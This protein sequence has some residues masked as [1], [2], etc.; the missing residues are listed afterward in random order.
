MS[1]HQEDHA[2]PLGEMIEEFRIVQV[3]GTGSFGVVYQGDNTY[4]DETVAIKEFL[5]TELASRMPNGRIEPLSAA[6]KEG[7]EWA[8]ERFLQEAKTLWGLAHP[9]RHRNIIR[10]TRFRKLNGSAYMFM[11][12]E[13][14]R[15]FSA[16]LEEQGALPFEELRDIVV[17]LL[18]GLGRVHSGGILHRDIKPANV[19][20]RSDGSPVLIDFGSARYVAK[21]GERSVFATFTPLYAA[22]EQHQ[23]VGEQGPWTDIYGLGAT[24]YRAVTGLAPKSASQRLLS[25]PQQPASE[26]CRGRYPES[27]LRAIDHA[28]A[29][30]PGK[31]PQSVAEWREELLGEVSTGV[32]A[33][34]VV[35][36]SGRPA[37]SEALAADVPVDDKPSTGRPRRAESAH[38]DGAVS[39]LSGERRRSR[40]VPMLVGAVIVGIT[41]IGSGWYLLQ[42]GG[43]EE[44]DT[45]LGIALPVA[46]SDRATTAD[47]YERLAIEHF[48]RNELERSIDLVELGLR[49]TPGDARLTKLRAYF[50]AH[51]Q[52]RQALDQA[53]E[54]AV[55][56][57]FDR[58][59]ALIDQGLE[60]LPEHAGLLDL[61]TRVV[62][63][64][65]EDRRVRA[66]QL[67]R[68]AERKREDGDLAGSLSLVEE[69]LRRS[70]TS[71]ELLALRDSIEAERQRQA[72]TAVAIGA[73]RD[74]LA[75]DDLEAGRRRL[76][77]ALRL[78]PDDPELRQLGAVL[79]QRQD[80]RDE[81]RIAELVDRARRVMDAGDPKRALALID[82]APAGDRE[83]TDVKALRGQVTVAIDRQRADEMLERA[84]RR[85]DR[86]E[87]TDSVKLI[88]QGL[89]LSPGHAGLTSLLEDARSASAARDEV[90][91]ILE[92]VRSLRR[93]GAIDEGLAPID[94]GLTL[95]PDNQE[96]IDLRAAMIRERQAI[97]DRR[98]ASL[99]KQA[100]DSRARGALEDSLR[101]IDEGLATA[102]SNEALTQLRVAVEAELSKN[103]EVERVLAQAR[104]LRQSGALK[105]SLAA[106]E[107]GLERD[108]G[109][110]P[111]LSLQAEVSREQRERNEL[112]V[113]SLIELAEQRRDAG[114]LARAVTSIQQALRLMPGDE[115]L[116][117]LRD[118]L[119]QVIDLQDQLEEILTS[120]EETLSGGSDDVAVLS[121]AGAC[122]QRAMSLVPDEPRAS[123]GLARVIAALAASAQRALDDGSIDDLDTRLAA[124]EALKPDFP[125][126]EGFRRDRQLL[127]RDLLP[128]LAAIE[129]GC[130]RM[131]SPDGEPGRESD[132]APHDVCI[133]GF[134]IA[135]EEVSVGDFERFVEATGYM[136]DAERGV[137]GA[138][139][140]WAFDS[141][142]GNDKWQYHSWAHWRQP[143]KYQDQ[144]SEHPVSCVSW[145][146]ANAYI[147]WLNEQTGRQFRLP[148]EAEWEYAA[149]A[150]TIAAQYWL[151]QQETNA[152]RF[153]SVA[154]TQ[155]GWDDGFPCGDGNEWVAEV[156]SFEANPWGLYDM[157]GNL[158]EW[159]C[160]AYDEAYAGSEQQCSDWRSDVPRV[161]R[162]GAWNSGP[163]VVRAAYRNRNYPE[164]RYNFVG[165]RLAQTPPGSDS[166]A[167][168]ASS[169]TVGAD[170]SKRASR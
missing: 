39:P 136:T 160:S 131:G 130:Y 137:G 95:Y 106:I 55:E 97:N 63:L 78:S 163:A 99:L 66:E 64:R 76:D 91:S 53:S 22:L 38:T 28:C 70:P 141:D 19:L 5:P 49:T 1:E 31:R 7:Y 147:A 100:R 126:L 121:R 82:G 115:R 157:L 84:K 156:S 61:R 69:G 158:W 4:L 125:G 15:P 112:A 86:G 159:T 170:A 110:A 88:N 77:Q 6:T 9:A 2:L 129:D 83:N 111:L 89:A 153:A 96:L 62:G 81:Q 93:E 68:Q 60:A 27:F 146:D 145:N 144:R 113:A 45:E 16:V 71:D 118:E 124:L 127:E 75:N 85:F 168:T 37:G 43:P 14:G 59:L 56:K 79:Q 162:G 151:E 47:N 90:A 114:E 52:A 148:T 138:Q 134:L 165:F 164:A 29:L 17:A 161:L 116:L 57:Q 3:L 26:L 58:A 23:E 73:I 101:L 41:L 33:P 20:I 65:D 104:A 34:T 142:N 21:G 42:P 140:C 8:L 105:D 150:G 10:V 18:S 54:A 133:D 46:H 44:Q 167:R 98:V 169:A 72:D 74:L 32:F 166:E 120:C 132:E 48:Q 139:G 12:F 87:L 80:A 13:R 35:K 155:H 36:T 102:P 50:A 123:T 67:L 149:R 25:D 51:K 40:Q 128:E 135:R 94:D 30:D 117:V 154:D 119:Q 108:P 11:E 109:N 103:N 24:M 143:N 107:R 152:C 92:T 122:F